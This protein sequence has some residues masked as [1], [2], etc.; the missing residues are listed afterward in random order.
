MFLA[1]MRSRLTQAERVK[2][3]CRIMALLRSCKI[4]DAPLNYESECCLAAAIL[5][6]AAAQHKTS[7]CGQKY[8]LKPCFYGRVALA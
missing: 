2:P 8:A 4:S 1:G 6:A 5:T 7:L 3:R